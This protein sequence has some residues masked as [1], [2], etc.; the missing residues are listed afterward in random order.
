MHWIQFI[1]CSIGC[2]VVALANQMV[3]RVVLLA[4]WMWCRRVFFGF[5]QP[6]GSK[7]DRHDRVASEMFRK[8]YWKLFLWLGAYGHP[9]PKH[10]MLLSNA[11]WIHNLKKPLSDN[12]RLRFSA[13]PSTYWSKNNK[14]TGRKQA[15]V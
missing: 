5:E 2:Q 15:H 8:L 3:S 10:T 12:D 1:V 9:Q 4:A 11:P 7:L 13:N 6:G 14:L